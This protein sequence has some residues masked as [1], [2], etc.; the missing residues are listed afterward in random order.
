[1]KKQAIYNQQKWV[2]FHWNNE[3]GEHFSIF[4]RGFPWV[5]GTIKGTEPACGRR[6]DWGGRGRLVGMMAPAKR[7]I[8]KLRR[9]NIILNAFEITDLG[10]YIHS[11]RFHPFDEKGYL[12]RLSPWLVPQNFAG[13]RAIST[14]SDSVQLSFLLLKSC[15]LETF[16][17]RYT[18]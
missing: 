8:W 18:F 10:C 7:L 12:T 14:E 4:W 1:M 2:I 5:P 11:L 15:G 16:W 9:L 13:K 17:F 3:F 6:Q